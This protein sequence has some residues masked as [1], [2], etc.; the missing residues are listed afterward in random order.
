[1]EENALGCPVAVSNVYAMP[2]QLGDAA[3]YFDPSS[4][5]EIAEAIEI[6]WTDEALCVELRER[7]FIQ[8]SKWN[9]SHFNKRLYNI[10]RNVLGEN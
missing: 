4:V 9:Q 3:L 1:M 6:L 7:G 10:V 2:E 8:A 5:T